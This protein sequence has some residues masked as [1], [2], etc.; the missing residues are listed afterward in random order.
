MSFMGQEAYAAMQSEIGFAD[1]LSA[2]PVVGAVRGLKRLCTHTGIVVVSAR[3]SEKMV[4]LNE[5]VCAHGLSKVITSVV[6][7]HGGLKADVARRLGAD[8]LIDDDQRHAFELS[9][10]TTFVHFGVGEESTGKPFFVAQDWIAVETLVL[11][12]L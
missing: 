8:W 7:S 1:T 11:A 10:E 9:N 12:R 3:P 2:P 6:T 5:W 4:W